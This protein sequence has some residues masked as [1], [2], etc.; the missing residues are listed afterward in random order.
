MGRRFK[1]YILLVFTSFLIMACESHGCFE[2]GGNE[3]VQEIEVDSF[4]EMSVYGLFELILVPDTID[5]VEFLAKDAVLPYLKASVDNE[6]MLLENSNNCFYQSDYTKVKAYIH[7]KSLQKIN[8]YEACKLRTGNPIVNTMSLIVQAEMAEVDIEISADRFYF[9]NHTTTG[10]KY[11]FRGST[12]YASIAGYY[13]AQF[14]LGE[15]QVRQLSINNSSIGDMHVNPL[16][17]L[18]VQIHNRGN[19]YYKGSPEIVI[20][21]VSGS[22]RLIWEE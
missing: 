15:L 7:Y 9:Y 21:S 19:I 18:N 8:L 10:G 6:I 22:G 5:F 11:T 1:L 3:R 13:M 17:K 14:N 12:D 20:D 16:E 2:K 4:T